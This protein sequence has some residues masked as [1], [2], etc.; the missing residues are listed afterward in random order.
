MATNGRKRYFHIDENAS[1]E[2]MYA[3]L[4]DIESAEEDD[5]D[6]LMN[7][8]D[9]EFLEIT[10]V[11]STQDTSLTTPEATLHV[12][13]C[14][15]QSKKKEKNKKEELWEWPKKVRVTKQEDCQHRP[16]IATQSK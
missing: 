6:N 9:T 8:S 12:V 16:T 5:I 15:N 11:A 3:L 1:G 4:D 7:D 13:P 2:Q 14:D 10:Q